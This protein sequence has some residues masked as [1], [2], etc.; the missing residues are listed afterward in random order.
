MAVK[1]SAPSKR[2]YSLG[3]RLEGSDQKRANILAAARAQLVSNGFPALTLD[4]L[5]RECG[6]TRQTIHNFFGTKTGVLEALFDQIAF[7]SGMEQMRHVMQLTEAEAMLEGFV[8]VFCTFWRRN[9][10]LI[11]RVHGIAAIDPEFGAAIEARNRR[12]HSAAT[13]VI[14]RI[15]QRRG[16]KAVASKEEQA[17]TLSALTSFEFFDALAESCGS[18]EAAIRLM[19]DIVRKSLVLQR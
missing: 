5:A 1:K 15:D 19:P 3:K 4:A 7:D 13:R 14:E 9:R 18:V 8:T 17:A 2:A 12:R 11:R 6:V 10:M 16:R